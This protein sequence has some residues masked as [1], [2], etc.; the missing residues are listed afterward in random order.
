MNRRCHA[1]QSAA[2]YRNVCLAQVVLH[3]GGKEN[4][5]V[6]AMEQYGC[7]TSS[8]NL[9]IRHKRLKIDIHISL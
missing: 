1:C 9:V 5:F 6:Y 8:L 7:D 2:N 3:P 4:N